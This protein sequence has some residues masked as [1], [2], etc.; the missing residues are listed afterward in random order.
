[1][2]MPPSGGQR[3]LQDQ[4]WALCNGVTW[5]GSGGAQK[6]Q[7]AQHPVV[8]APTLAAANGNRGGESTAGSDWSRGAELVLAHCLRKVREMCQQRCAT[9]LGMRWKRWLKSKP[10]TLLGETQ[11]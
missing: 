11:K 8:G 7:E 6:R 3:R 9:L 2:G 4:A 5:G 1:M 10:L